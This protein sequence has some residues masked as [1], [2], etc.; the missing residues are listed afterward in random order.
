MFA[1]FL[2]FVCLL[3][4]TFKIYEMFDEPTFFMSSN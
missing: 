4:E 3:I 1:H 2:L